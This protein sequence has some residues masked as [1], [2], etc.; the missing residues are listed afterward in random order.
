M[1]LVPAVMHLLGPANWWL[2][3]W[4]GPATRRPVMETNADHAADGGLASTRRR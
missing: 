3:S 2:P 1:M 4:P